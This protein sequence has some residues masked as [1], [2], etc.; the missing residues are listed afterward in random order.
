MPKYYVKA[1]YSNLAHDGSLPVP[2]KCT[3]IA[4][5]N[6]PMINLLMTGAK[7]NWR[8]NSKSHQ[9]AES[10]CCWQELSRFSNR[11]ILFGIP[12][13]SFWSTFWS[14]CSNVTLTWPMVS[15]VLSWPILV[16]SFP[17]S[18]MTWK[19]TADILFWELFIGAILVRFFR[20]I[21]RLFDDSLVLFCQF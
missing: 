8:P 11:Q 6:Y 15:S 3:E 17:H 1:N 19:E 16:G 4:L 9:L 10:N 21:F 14:S 5:K 7:S 20:C 2:S 13:D 18:K 12:L